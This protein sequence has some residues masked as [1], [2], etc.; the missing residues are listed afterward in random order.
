LTCLFLIAKKIQ[1]DFFEKLP[2]EGTLG[3]DYT[4]KI[5][6]GQELFPSNRAIFKTELLCLTEEIML[7]KIVS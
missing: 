7:K 3:Q 6:A 2:P 1:V 4:K 5:K